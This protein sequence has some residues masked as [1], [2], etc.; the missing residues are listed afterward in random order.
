MADQKLFDVQL[1]SIL[2]LG[3]G[4]HKN[5]KTDAEKRFLNPKDLFDQ[6]LEIKI[7]EMVFG[8]LC[9][10]HFSDELCTIIPSR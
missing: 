2:D 3:N 4:M 8:C 1:G 5:V 6:T 7:P 9:H 10:P